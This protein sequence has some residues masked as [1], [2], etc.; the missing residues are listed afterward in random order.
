MHTSTRKYTQ[1]K[2]KPILL[3]IYI[4]IYIY[5]ALNGIMRALKLIYYTGWS[6]ACLIVVAVFFCCVVVHEW[7]NSTLE[8]QS[9]EKKSKANTKPTKKKLS[10]KLPGHLDY[11]ITIAFH[12]LANCIC[13]YIYIALVDKIYSIYVNTLRMFNV[14]PRYIVFL[15]KQFNYTNQKQQSKSCRPKLYMWIIKSSKFIFI[16]CPVGYDNGRNN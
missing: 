1:K 8:R 7:F 14:F 13:I 12:A 10:A 9:N 16:Y 3:L 2:H 11:Y 6:A 4:Y 15:R 5:I